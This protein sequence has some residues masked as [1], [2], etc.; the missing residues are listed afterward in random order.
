MEPVEEASVVSEH[1]EEEKASSVGSNDKK[2]RDQTKRIII[3][4]SALMAEPVYVDPTRAAFATTMDITKLSSTHLSV[5]AHRSV[6]KPKFV[7]CHFC[8][9]YERL[10]ATNCSKCNSSLSN[11]DEMK[12]KLLDQENEELERSK[13]DENIDDFLD[14]CDKC[15]NNFVYGC[16]Y[17]S[18][19]ACLFCFPFFEIIQMIQHWDNYGGC[20][21]YFQYLLLSKLL[22][23]I[24]MYT[25]IGIHYKFPSSR[26]VLSKGFI[27]IIGLLLFFVWLI[28]A[29]IIFWG[30][31]NFDHSHCNAHDVHTAGYYDFMFVELMFVYAIFA[32]V[33]SYFTWIT[34]AKN[35][36]IIKCIVYSQAGANAICLPAAVPLIE[37]IM[38][39]I[40]W[41]N[42][43]H[44]S[45]KFEWN[46]SR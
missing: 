16:I 26:S 11:E 14:C 23:T 30:D 31:D 12:D 20:S 1:K 38:L 19:F 42:H 35:E 45:D 3:P 25:L 34:I 18:I 10:G 44:C 22:I 36:R 43:G 27:L 24:L 17:L 9:K 21:V 28:L 8:G 15:M 32:F 33:T 39:A 37:I 2:T 46:S 41:D 40:F 5:I 13:A 4:E 29:S 6:V 7:K